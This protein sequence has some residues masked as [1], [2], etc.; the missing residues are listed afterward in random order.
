MEPLQGSL[1][2]AGSAGADHPRDSDFRSEVSNRP[3]QPFRPDQPSP[4]SDSQVSQL[5]MIAS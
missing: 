5:H 2:A 3:V 4:G 1:D